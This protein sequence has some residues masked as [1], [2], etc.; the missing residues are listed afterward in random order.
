MD[1]QNVRKKKKEIPLRKWFID[2]QEYIR[3]LKLL[4]IALCGVNL[5]SSYVDK[6]R[7]GKERKCRKEF[8]AKQQ[9]RRDF[10]LYKVSKKEKKNLLLIVMT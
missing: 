4:Q 9:S 1:H 7:K 10:D 6:K 3:E 2:Y 5:P 8:R